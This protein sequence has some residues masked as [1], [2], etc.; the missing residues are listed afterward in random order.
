MGFAMQPAQREGSYK[1]VDAI[2][3]PV[4]P[5]PQETHLVVGVWSETEIKEFGQIPTIMLRPERNACCL[6]HR[7]S[8]QDLGPCGRI[9]FGAGHTYGDG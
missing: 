3:F 8:V 1:T 7:Q 5:L 6:Q 2:P 4:Q 9:A